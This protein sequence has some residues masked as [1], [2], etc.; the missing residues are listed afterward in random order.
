MLD[1]FM[2]L[3]SNPDLVLF[4]LDRCDDNLQIDQRLEDST[5]NYC[6]IKTDFN[7]NVFAAGRP[8]DFG[9]R[10]L[11][12]QGIDYQHIVFL[13]GDCLPSPMLFQEHR[14]IHEKT[15]MFVKYPVLV[16]A[17]RININE[18][19]SQTPDPR[20][21]NKN[22]FKSGIDVVTVYDKHLYV[23]DNM[24]PACVG[25]NV[26]LNKH[27]IA[28]ARK[29]NT[30]ITGSARVFAHVFDGQWGGE[31]PYLSATLFRAGALCVN[32]HPDTAYVK[33]CWHVGTHRNNNH[34]RYLIQALSKFNNYSMASRIVL[35][36]TKIICEPQYSQSVNTALDNAI[37]IKCPEITRLASRDLEYL[38]SNESDKW[39]ATFSASRV[40]GFEAPKKTSLHKRTTGNYNV[41][42]QKALN[43]VFD[44]RS[45]HLTE[46]Y[47]GIYESH[48]IRNH[49][50]CHGMFR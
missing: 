41:F 28:L 24:Y 36:S 18:D 7:D 44:L 35:P 37:D 19:G 50:N 17:M 16:N 8:R 9:I 40:Y 15:H 27:A 38:C 23:D 43:H 3:Y 21:H 12:R 2:N 49:H 22:I 30:I 32:A 14:R 33:H 20:I 10:F 6:V 29:I 1:A 13:D 48:S 31:D 5:L 47:P 4:V 39:L 46:D 45:F 42:L 25:C 11:E 26:S 34:V